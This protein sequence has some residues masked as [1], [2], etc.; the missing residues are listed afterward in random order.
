MKKILVIIFFLIGFCISIL[1]SLNLNQ[2]QQYV[3][4]SGNLIGFDVENAETTI[5]DNLIK[6]STKSLG[7]LTF[8]DESNNFA[9]LGHSIGDFSYVDGNCYD[10]K[11]NNIEKS[12][13]EKIGSV[14]GDLLKDSSLAVINENSPYGIFGK[15]TNIDKESFR[16]IEIA[17]KFDIQT[18]EAYILSDIEGSGVKEYKIEITY[19][20]YLHDTQNIKI[21]LV[22][23][24]LI[25]K[26]GGFLQGMSGSPIIQNDKLIGAL[27]YASSENPLEG[28]GVFVE[29]LLK[30]R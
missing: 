18:G 27:N 12:K 24:E 9:A 19:V 20:D 10:I 30:N 28:Y 16:K 11:I 25:E 2:S 29:K 23:S 14:N 7:T 17:N 22:D 13:S 15:A 8:I 21:K 5:N 6:T 3:Y 4:V 1:V 26:T